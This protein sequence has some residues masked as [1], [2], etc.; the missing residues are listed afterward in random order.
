MF[1]SRYLFTH[2]GR[3]SLWRGPTLCDRME[4]DASL[5]RPVIN[6]AASNCTFPV[7]SSSTR[8]NTPHTSNAYSKIRLMKVM[9]I[10]NNACRFNKYLYFHYKN[11]FT[12]IVNMNRQFDFAEKVKPKCLW[13]SVMFNTRLGFGCMFALVKSIKLALYLLK[14][15]RYVS[16]HS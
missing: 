5:G 11:R 16:D 3:L 13:V 6:L 15:T 7:L 8:E 10:F 2:T 1:T 4:M 12:N 14:N 9:N